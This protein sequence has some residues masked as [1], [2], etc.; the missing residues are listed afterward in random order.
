[1]CSVA[2]R[3]HASE[4]VAMLGWGRR[5]APSG[6][7][8][9][10]QGEAPCNSLVSSAWFLGQWRGCRSRCSR[11]V[12]R[13]WS[14]DSRSVKVV[15]VGDGWLWMTLL[16]RGCCWCGAATQSV[17]CGPRWHLL[18]SHGSGGLLLVVPRLSHTLNRVSHYCVS[19]GEISVG[20]KWNL[21]Y[22][23]LCVRGCVR[24]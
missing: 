20:P 24:G 9:Q 19:C 5:A 8:G 7:P 2:E 11:C 3:R 18:V 4:G 6:R 14:R 22:H 1:M 15:S 12:S 21:K 13:W 23:A 17:A 10:R 16:A